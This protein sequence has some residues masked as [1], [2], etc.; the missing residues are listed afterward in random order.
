MPAM[1]THTQ[2]STQIHSEKPGLSDG[3][4]FRSAVCLF[5]L[6]LMTAIGRSQVNTHYKRAPLLE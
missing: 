1:R 3:T 5:V 2:V 6:L 4:N